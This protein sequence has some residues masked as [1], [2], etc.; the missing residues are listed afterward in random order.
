MRQAKPR[1]VSFNLLLLTLCALSTLSCTLQPPYRGVGLRPQP[2]PFEQR[3]RYLKELKDVSV[4][5]YNTFKVAIVE[6]NDELTL[7][8]AGQLEAAAAAI[9]ELPSDRPA[10]VV[11]F[12]HGW[13][14]NARVGDPHLLGFETVLAALA[15]DE[16]Q[17]IIGIYVGW[18]GLSLRGPAYPFFPRS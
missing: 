11:L 6:F 7:A 1:I 18:R 13:G 10:T 17:S 16:K 2:I 4:E 9:K 8:R 12:I 15:R 14:H 5:N 3:E